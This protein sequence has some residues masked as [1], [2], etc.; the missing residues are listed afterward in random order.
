M[1]RPARLMA[2][3]AAAM[4]SLGAAS[5]GEPQTQ[6]A[7]G[8]GHHDHSHDATATHSFDDVGK[9]AGIFDDPSRAEWQKPESI[10]GLLGLKPGMTVADIGA[11]TGYFERYFATAVGAEGRVYAVDIEPKMV[12][13]MQER[14]RREK[15]PNVIPTLGAPDDP[16]LPAASVDVV[17]IC[18][19]YHHLNDRTDYLRRLTGV[20]RPGG[21]VAVLDFH[22]R[23]LPVGPP[24][25]HKLSREE[26]LAEFAEAGWGASGESDLLP[27]QY[28]LI[29]TPPPPA[30]R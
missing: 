30:P 15:T 14:A 29:F 28:F 18:D 22:K 4:L 11:G 5:S 16:K 12:A 25:E 3:S 21:R 23:E 6:P 17:F 10:P 2:A 24:V 26:V 20:L 13:Y 7:S 27:Y 8:P 19:T 1:T 9:W